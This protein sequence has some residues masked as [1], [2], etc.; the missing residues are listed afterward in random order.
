MHAPRSTACATELSLCCDEHAGRSQ[1]TCAM[2]SRSMRVA[3]LRQT[4]CVACATRL[5]VAN[6]W[7]HIQLP[8]YAQ[9][10]CISRGNKALRKTSDDRI[11]DVDEVNRIVRYYSHLDQRHQATEEW[12]AGA[13]A[14]DHFLTG[15]PNISLLYPTRCSGRAQTPGSH[16]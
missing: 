13:V 2:T 16:K 12:W 4:P 10:E 11:L 8:D 5:S 7:H 6:S 9:P 14:L 3:T 1:Q 15:L